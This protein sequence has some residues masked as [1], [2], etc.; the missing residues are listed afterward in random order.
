MLLVLS[1]V[2]LLR[3]NVDKMKCLFIPV[4][5]S[6][7]VFILNVVFLYMLLEACDHLVHERLELFHLILELNEDAGH[8][9]RHKLV[10]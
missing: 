5:H 9:V 4:F 2:E 6:K 8:L 7:K 1:N 10:V 3:C